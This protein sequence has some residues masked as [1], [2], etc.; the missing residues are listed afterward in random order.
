[1][2][3]ILLDL[4]RVWFWRILAVVPVARNWSWK[5]RWIWPVLAPRT[6]PFLSMFQ[7]NRSRRIIVFRF[8]PLENI[9]YFPGRKIWK[10]AKF[11]LFQKRKR[12]TRKANGQCIKYKSKY[13]NPKFSIDFLQ[14]GMTK[15]G[16]WNVF[17]SLL[18][19]KRSFLT[20]DPSE[21][22]SLNAAPTS[23]SFP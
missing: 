1:M 20:T 15:S 10:N 4:W 13:P 7:R 18:V 11:F 6:F 12:L 19:I 14:A 2:G 5:L 17:Q 9:P 23:P 22:F 21:I 3:D 8:G 16:L